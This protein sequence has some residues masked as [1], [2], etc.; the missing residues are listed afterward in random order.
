MSGCDRAENADTGQAQRPHD[1]ARQQH[2]AHAG[3]DAFFE[4]EVQQAGSQRAGPRARAG[5]GDAHE[6]QQRPEEAAARPGPELFAGVLALYQAEGEKPA[7]DRLVPSP[8]QHPA[9][10]EINE[11]DGEHITDDGDDIR[12]PQGQAEGHAVGDRAAELDDGDHGDEKNDDAVLQHTRMLTFTKC[13]GI[14]PLSPA[15]GKT[16]KENTKKS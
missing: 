1:Q 11:G 2:A 13:S 3:Q 8:L 12:Q 6:Q 15:V 14:I 4:I 5:Q 10:E 7:D 9:G 16:D